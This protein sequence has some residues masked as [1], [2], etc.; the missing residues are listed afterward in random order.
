MK[1]TRIHTY[2]LPTGVLGMALTPDGTRGIA[3]CADGQ[4]SSVDLVTGEAE[5]LAAK[6][7]SYASGCVLLPDGRT[8]IS[9]GYDGQ[10]IWH[11]L[12]SRREVRRVQAHGFWSW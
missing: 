5:A 6:H 8:V 4:V 9:G 3:A 10:L 7:D 2:K 11:D 12:E 1:L